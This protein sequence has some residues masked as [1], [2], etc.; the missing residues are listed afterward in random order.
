MFA[1]FHLPGGISAQR[2][3]D[4]DDADDTNIRRVYDVDDGFG[5]T[6]KAGSFGALAVPLV[7]IG[8]HLLYVEINPLTWRS[9]HSSLDNSERKLG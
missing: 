6:T 1:A 8:T 3:D 7:L 9:A 2:Y 4:D 5:G